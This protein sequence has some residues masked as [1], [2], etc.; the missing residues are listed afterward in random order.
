MCYV[1]GEDEAF[2]LA[3]KKLEITNRQTVINDIIGDI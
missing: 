3:C 2:K 1:V